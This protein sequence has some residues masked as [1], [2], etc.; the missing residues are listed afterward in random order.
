MSSLYTR[1][2]TKHGADRM[3]LALLTSCLSVCGFENLPTAHDCS[4]DA[5][6]PDGLPN[7]TTEATL[8]P[9]IGRAGAGARDTQV[10]WV[11]PW[12]R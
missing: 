3:E 12:G 5:V 7:I 4:R 2:T 6:T 9:M 10:L 1:Q 11:W 8:C